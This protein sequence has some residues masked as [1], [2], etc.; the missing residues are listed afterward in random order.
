[1]V[2]AFGAL[3]VASGAML[4]LPVA[5]RQLID[6]GMSGGDPATVNRY[7]LG[8]LGAALAHHADDRAATQLVADLPPA[9]PVPAPEPTTAE[10]RAWAR[11]HGLPVPDRGRLHP[12][13]WAAYRAD[14]AGESS[15]EAE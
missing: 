4:A 6:R 2:L 13:I 3:L 11:E 14:V 10:V 15:P 12:D 9:G 7:F 5:V 8:F 1:M